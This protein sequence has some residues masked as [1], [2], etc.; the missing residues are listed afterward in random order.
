VPPEMRR[1]LATK[2]GVCKFNIGTEFRQCFGNAL[3]TVLAIETTLFDRIAILD[4]TCQPLQASAER[5]IENLRR[6][7]DDKLF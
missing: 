5:V 7:T 3:R 6:E 4:K 2:T 1:H